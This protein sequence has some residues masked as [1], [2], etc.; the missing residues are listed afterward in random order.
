M[1]IFIFF[2]LF[3]SARDG[4]RRLQHPRMVLSMERPNLIY[5]CVNVSIDAMQIAKIASTQTLGRSDPLL[6]PTGD[7][8]WGTW[9]E[10][11]ELGSPGCQVRGR[12]SPCSMGILSDTDDGY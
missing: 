7:R 1:Y 9:T 11:W 2:I 4:G 3:V 5:I 8:F 12:D 6:H 10:P